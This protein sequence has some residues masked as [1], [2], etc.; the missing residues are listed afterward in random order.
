MSVGLLHTI[1]HRHPE[2]LILW[3]PWPRDI[4]SPTPGSDE[5]MP[6][7]AAG[8]PILRPVS[9]CPKPCVS[10]QMG[11]SVCPTLHPIYR[12]SIAPVHTILQFPSGSAISRTV[13]LELPLADRA[14]VWSPTGKTVIP[15]R[16]VG[17]LPSRRWTF[18][19]NYL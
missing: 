18:A 17:M 3:P 14:P 13:T 12:H 5:G 2:G 6:G 4:P 1:T 19:I 7:C 8:G 16:Q 15:T 11:V 9:V 10:L